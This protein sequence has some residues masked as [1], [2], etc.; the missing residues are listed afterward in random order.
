MKIHSLPAISIVVLLL[1]TA[2]A[3]STEWQKQHTKGTYEALM[4]LLEEDSDDLL[5]S[6]IDLDKIKS[7]EL[8]SLKPG[9]HFVYSGRHFDA[10]QVDRTEKI[11]FLIHGVDEPGPNWDTALR[12][13]VRRPGLLVFYFVWTKWNR[14]HS[15]EYWIGRDISRLAKAL[16][17]QVARMDVVAHSAGGVLLLQALCRPDSSRLCAYKKTEFPD[18]AVKFHTIAS[19]LGGFGMRSTA[20]ASPFAGAVTAHIGSIVYYWDMIPDIDLTVWFTSFETDKV[21]KKQQDRDMRFPQFK[22]EAPVVEKEPLSGCSHDSSIL[23]GL[24][25]IFHIPRPK[26]SPVEGPWQT[27]YK[28]EGKVTPF[29]PL[30]PDPGW[31]PVEPIDDRWKAVDPATGEAKPEQTKNAP[32]GGVQRKDG[33]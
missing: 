30:P 32:D 12:L 16:S 6:S 8:W 9:L 14:P 3:G 4:G 28:D 15:V 5:V 31:Q 10:Q 24:V 27:I 2:R 26:D 22:G 23:H 29:Q 19:P 18:L 17:K 13:L 21:L 25:R 1:F 7:F 20:M 33:D 11:V